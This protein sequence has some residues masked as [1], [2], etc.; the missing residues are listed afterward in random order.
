MMTFGNGNTM[1]VGLADQLN[2]CLYGRP[3]DDVWAMVALP[4]VKG[5]APT[6]D[7]LDARALEAL[8]YTIRERSQD[9]YDIEILWSVR[10]NAYVLMGAT[11]SEATD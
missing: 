10:A 1:E 9:P 3:R 2:D 6:I 5:C 7:E 11:D 8:H 4:S